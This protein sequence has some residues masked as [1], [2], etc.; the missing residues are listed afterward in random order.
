MRTYNIF[1]FI[2]CLT[3]SIP[4]GVCAIRCAD[5]LDYTGTLVCTLCSFAMIMLGVH[6]ALQ[7]LPRGKHRHR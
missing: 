6:Y 3:G 7:A 1:R 5:R 4:T 2:C